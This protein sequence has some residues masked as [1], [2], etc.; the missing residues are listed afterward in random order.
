MKVVWITVVNR[1]GQLLIAFE[2][3]GKNQV[4]RLELLPQQLAA[5]CSKSAEILGQL[6]TKP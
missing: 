1:D 6:I 5:V 3:V 4:E 2:P